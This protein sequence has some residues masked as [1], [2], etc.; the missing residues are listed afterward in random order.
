[1]TTPDGIEAGSAPSSTPVP[2]VRAGLWRRPPRWL[3][4]LALVPPM[5][6][7]LWSLSTP[8]RDSRLWAGSVVA[9]AIGAVVWI[10]RSISYLLTRPGGRLEGRTSW[11]LAAPVA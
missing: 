8:G 1:M 7:L 11:F 3:F 5:I 2:K 9:L 6:G 10:A 4:H